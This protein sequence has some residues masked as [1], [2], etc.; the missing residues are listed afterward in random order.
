METVKV[1]LFGPVT[2]S[3]STFGR[4]HLMFEELEILKVTDVLQKP[5]IVPSP[6]TH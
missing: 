1:A 5:P 4:R 3:S 2:S 6:L